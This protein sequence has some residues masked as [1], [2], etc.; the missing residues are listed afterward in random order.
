[1]LVGRSGY[2]GVVRSYVKQCSRRKGVKEGFTRKA[3]VKRWRGGYRTDVLEGRS[4]SCNYVKRE[5]RF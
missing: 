3:R 2:R 4:L 1:M 5:Y